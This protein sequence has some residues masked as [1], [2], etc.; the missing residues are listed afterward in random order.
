[1]GYGTQKKVNLTGAV[2]TVNSERIANKPVTSMVSALTG[3]AAGVTIRQQYGTP[4]ANQ[5]EVRI[6][7]IGTWGD[8]SPLVLVDG[9]S[10]SLDNVIPSEV[11]SVTILKDAASSAIYGSRAANG[12]ILITT[13]QG[14]K[15]KIRL[16]YDANVAVQKATRLPEIAE[17]WQ[18]AEYY[19]QAQINDGQNPL[20]S[21]ESIS[22]MKSGTGNPDNL[23]ANTKWLNE[24][25]AS[26]PV[27]QIHQIS[28]TGG[29]E[30]TTYMALLGYSNQ[31]GLL[32]NTAYE[33]Y[34]ARI[35]TRTQFTSWL[36]LSFN[37]S[38]LNG[39]VQRSSF[40]PNAAFG[41]AS[42]PC[43]IPLYPVKYSDG[44]WSHM[45]GT[46][47]VRALATDDYG[48][49]RSRNNLISTLIS[50]EITPL[51]GLVIKGVFGYDANIT[52]NKTFSKI[53]QYD[54]FG[55]VQAPSLSQSRNSQTDYWSLG[56]NMTA[57]ATATYEFNL[58]MNNFKVM[59]GAS[60]ES[61]NWAYTQASRMDFP[62]NDFT[63]ISGGD[64]NTASAS[65]NS[66][67][68]A[69]VSLF[70]RLNYDFAGKY[71]FEANFRYDGSSKF[72]RG[73]RYGFFPSFSAGWRISEEAFFESL[74][75]Y[76]SNLKLRGS[77]GIL[78]NQQIS[79]YQYLSTYGASGVYYF[80]E[81]LNTGYTESVMGN[82]L[83]TWE[84]SK[85]LN[86]GLDFSILK[87]RLSTSFEW[88]DKN[89]DNILLNLAA[90]STLG[91]SPSMQNAGSVENKG[92]ELTVKWQ[93]R[94]NDFNYH[95]GLTF[96]DVRNKVIDL[97]GYKSPTND[98]TI[99]I[100]GEPLDA[101]YGWESLGLCTSQEQYE[102]YKGVMQALNPNWNIGDIILKD[103]DGDGAITSDDKIIIGNQ[104][105]RYCYGLNLGFEW[106]D[107]DFTAFFKA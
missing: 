64:A 40:D 23:E 52:L 1:V 101:L 76:I 70:G 90:P 96:W 61:F 5:G 26:F 2:S 51:K 22:R 14:D 28:A 49:Y 12:V 89:T 41:Y 4:Q 106:K 47:P 36:N 9:V 29:T 15:G 59:A 55:T 46:N 35:N 103:R 92:W 60:A 10:A 68:N 104:I 53:L 25:L 54:A 19:N 33:R 100:E 72:A 62:N 84:S 67:Y 24:I 48:T 102:K 39:L 74:K 11:E 83:I 45:S 73:N 17:N 58:G 93:D 87:D 75:P 94:I 6:R 44:T 79:D 50:P 8:A 88:Y 37:L 21:A 82:A 99:R 18:F 20:Y 107:F 77:W 32:K 63:E 31:K 98:L 38:Y 95:A 105:P 86:F 81:T 13:K 3:E 56:R 78:G 65:G 7:G 16:T 30:K 69:L 66:T 97:K 80:N 42:G 43:A 91:I 34:N 27:Q 57:N 85:N 71:L